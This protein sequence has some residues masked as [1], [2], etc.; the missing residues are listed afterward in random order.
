M[1]SIPVDSR[2]LRRFLQTGRSVWMDLFLLGLVIA[3]VGILLHYAH[4]A[5][6]PFLAKS[7]ID[8]SVSALPGYAGLTLARGLIAYVIALLF[9]LVYG[10]IAAHSV[11]AN[12][13]M[14]PLLDILQ[15]LPVLTFLWPVQAAMIVIFPDSSIGLEITVIIMVFTGQ[16]W[17]MTFSFYQSLR[18]LPPSLR[19]VARVNGFGPIRTFAKIELPASMIG[20]VYNSMVSF[21]GGWFFITSIELFTVNTTDYSLP[22]IGSWLVTVQQQ[23]QWGS[24]ATGLGVMALMIILV[25]QL[26]F[27]PVL[28]WAQRFRMEDQAASSG[29]SSWLVAIW[30]RSPLLQAFRAWRFRRRGGDVYGGLRVTSHGLQTRQVVRE[31]APGRRVAMTVFRWFV[32][33]CM[34]GLLGWGGWGMVK[35]LAP[36]PFWSGS[37]SLKT[38]DASWITA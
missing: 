7:S 32:I 22:G 9:T 14:V 36:L 23:G 28:V 21:A 15:T 31:T 6:R 1:T 19:E 12:R 8:T 33:I 20:L 30:R 3:I 16:A 18:T 5:E 24:M 11:R 38:E 10:W 27:R 13:V 25:D 34:L 37:I 4:E 26:I 2:P 29:E 35:L 17:N